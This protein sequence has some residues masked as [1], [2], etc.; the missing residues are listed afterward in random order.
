MQRK[1]GRDG[2]KQR[3]KAG[4]KAFALRGAL[5]SNKESIMG[6]GYWGGLGV[7]G[8]VAGFAIFHVGNFAVL[9]GDAPA[10]PAAV[11]EHFRPGMSFRPAAGLQSGCTQAPIDRSTGQTTPVDCGGAVPRSTT[12]TARL[13]EPA[14]QR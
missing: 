13:G 11:S 12:L 9:G 14:P 1:S 2:R 7:A 4:A 6:V 3:A 8:V 10:R 5:A